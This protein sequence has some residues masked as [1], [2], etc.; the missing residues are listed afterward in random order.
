MNIENITANL[1][2][3]GTRIAKLNINN[4]F[5]F[6]DLNDENI[7]REIDVSYELSPA[8]D[9]EDEENMTAQNIMMY[10]RLM[11]MD[12]EL[13]ANIDLDLEGCFIFEGTDKEQLQDM[14][15]VNGT[16]TLYSI[17]RGIISSITSHMCA[18]GTLLLPMINMFRLRD[19][20]NDLNG[21]N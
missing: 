9:V 16:A 19:E 4:E 5:V 6:I 10:I 8:F 14:L 20:L 18:N 17:A 2:I 15:T 11:I 3:I 21:N 12:D 7:S 1:Q 13:H